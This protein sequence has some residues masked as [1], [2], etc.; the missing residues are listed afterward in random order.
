KLPLD[1]LDANGTRVI[2][3][4]FTAGGPAIAT[5]LSQAIGAG[6]AV[7]AAGSALTVLDD[8]AANTTD[9]GALTGHSTSTGVQD[10]GLGLNL[11]VDRGTGDFTNSLGGKGQ[12]L[13]FAGR[14]AVN[15]GIVTD[16]TLLVK[17]TAATSLGDA[18][19]PDYL[20]NQLQSM[21]FA[22]TQT[23]AVQPGMFRLGGTVSDLIAQTVNHTGSIAQAAASDDD[24]QQ[25]TIETLAQRMDAEYGV[26]VDEEMARL[27]ELQSAYAANSR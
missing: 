8:G 19:R 12:R 9:V 27:M 11:F 16:N 23:G 22:S 6:F 5:R 7:S 24:T 17:T 4:D 15:E 20:L 26:N 2:G 10:G 25:L 21:R 3:M 14:I 13:G 18:T 1:Y